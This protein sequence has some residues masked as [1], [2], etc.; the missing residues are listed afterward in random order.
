MAKRCFYSKQFTKRSILLFILFFIIISIVILFDTQIAKKN[1]GDKELLLEYFCYCYYYQYYFI[2]IFNII[3]HSFFAFSLWCCFSIAFFFW[4]G[5]FS[6][7]CLGWNFSEIAFFSGRAGF[8]GR[9]FF[10]NG[11]FLRWL[12]VWDGIFLAWIVIIISFITITILNN[13]TG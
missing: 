9:H 8:Q 5:I 12:I 13:I 7:I 1:S 11:I 6:G 10:W 3:R 2:L 4:N